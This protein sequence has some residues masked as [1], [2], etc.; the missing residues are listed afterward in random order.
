[1][2]SSS[3]KSSLGQHNDACKLY[4]TIFTGIQSWTSLTK[5]NTGAHNTFHS[6]ETHLYSHILR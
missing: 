4:D 6:D 2:L 3:Y 1:M 5:S